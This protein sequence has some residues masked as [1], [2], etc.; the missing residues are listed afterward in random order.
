MTKQNFSFTDR[1]YQ[2][3]VYPSTMISLGFLHLLLYLNIIYT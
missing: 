2:I 1:L 3:L